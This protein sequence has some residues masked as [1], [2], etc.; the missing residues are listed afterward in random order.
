MA[1]KTDDQMGLIGLQEDLIAQHGY[2]LEEHR[3]TTDDGYSLGMHR[4]PNGRQREDPWGGQ[5]SAILVQ[6][7]VLASSLDWILTGPGNALGQSP[8]SF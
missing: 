6:H 4:I 8:S 3:V 2:P 5:R 7:G 1:D